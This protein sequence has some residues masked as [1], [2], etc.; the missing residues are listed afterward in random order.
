MVAIGAGAKE[1]E[2]VIVEGVEAGV[3]ES[4][5]LQEVK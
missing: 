4:T 5:R 3:R 1:V 2:E